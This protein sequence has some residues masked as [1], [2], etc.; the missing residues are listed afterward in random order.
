MDSSVSF[1][2]PLSFHP[3]TALDHKT[4]HTCHKTNANFPQND[5]G[6]INNLL[7]PVA[8]V[9]KPIALGTNNNNNIVIDNLVS[10]HNLSHTLFFAHF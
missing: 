8:L 3:H 2:I 9:Y 7:V 5:T 1:H 6:N 4:I 10:L